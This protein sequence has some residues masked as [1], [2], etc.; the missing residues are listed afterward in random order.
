MNVEAINMVAAILTAKKNPMFVLTK[1]AMKGFNSVAPE[2]STPI[3]VVKQS[4]EPIKIRRKH[5]ITSVF[6]IHSPSAF[7]KILVFHNY[8]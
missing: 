5:S 4:I 1:P 6:S 7:S 2:Y 8:I 3:V